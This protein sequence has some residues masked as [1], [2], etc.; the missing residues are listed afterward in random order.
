MKRNIYINGKVEQLDPYIL[1][2]FWGVEPN[3]DLN[4]LRVSCQQQR[5]GRGYIHTNMF[6]FHWLFSFQNVNP[7]KRLSAYQ[8]QTPSILTFT[9][10]GHVRASM[11]WKH[12]VDC[13]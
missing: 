6:S 11:N 8:K 4:K 9:Y 2:F 10:N 13:S 5:G 3:C 7:D 12:I 1:Q